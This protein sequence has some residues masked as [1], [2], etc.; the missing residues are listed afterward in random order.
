MDVDIDS[1]LDVLLEDSRTIE[2]SSILFSLE[3]IEQGLLLGLIKCLEN[4]YQLGINY[5]K[6]VGDD[7]KPLRAEYPR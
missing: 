6:D 4:N 3:K 7:L 1:M 2:K 5:Y